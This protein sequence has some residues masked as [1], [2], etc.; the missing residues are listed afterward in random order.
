MFKRLCA[1]CPNH[2]IPEQL[3][4]QYFYEGIIP[5]ECAMIDVASGGNLVDK[6]PQE[7]RN[8]IA[9]MV[10]NTQSFLARQ[11][12]VKKVD[13]SN[14]SSVEQQLSTLTNIVDKLDHMLM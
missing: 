8:L 9:N 10:G 4:I 2:Q 5:N 13:M 6:T 14:S 3:L 12:N 1:N 11:E 7:A